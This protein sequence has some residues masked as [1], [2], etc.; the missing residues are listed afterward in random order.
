M[1]SEHGY[2]GMIREEPDYL[3][4]LARAG[5]R[6]MTIRGEPGIG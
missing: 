3:R 1:L 4:P 2:L 6:E 5:I